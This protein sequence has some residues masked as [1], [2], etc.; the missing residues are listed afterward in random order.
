M[1]EGCEGVEAVGRLLGGPVAPEQLPS[2]IDAHLGHDGAPVG[3]VVGG[4]FDAR[5]QVLFAVGAQLPYGQLTSCEDDRLGEV[6]EHEGESRGGECHGVGAVEDD[7]SVVVVVFAVDDAH[8]LCPQRRCH[9]TGVDGRREMVGVDAS[10]QVFELRQVA[11]EVVEIERFQGIGHG[12]ASHA[13]GSSGVDHQHLAC[14]PYGK[15]L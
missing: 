12:V 2:E 11:H 9:V 6:L 10:A 1:V 8:E 7:E 4:Q 14:A 5:H 3:M 13:N 15:R